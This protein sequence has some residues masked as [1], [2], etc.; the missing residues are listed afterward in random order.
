[1]AFLGRQGRF[2][3]L[4]VLYNPFR[5]GAPIHGVFSV[6][7]RQNRFSNS[8]PCSCKSNLHILYYYRDGWPFI[9]GL[10]K[11]NLNQGRNFGVK[12]ARRDFR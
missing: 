7:F 8:I 3:I 9:H 11:I 4:N 2:Q 6:R 1:M 12:P 5:V 10:R